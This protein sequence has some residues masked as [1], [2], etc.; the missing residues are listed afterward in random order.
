MNVWRSS[1]Q[2]IEINPTNQEAVTVHVVAFDAGVLKVE[3]PALMNAVGKGNTPGNQTFAVMNTGAASLAYTVTITGAWL[4]CSS[5]SGSVEPN[6]TNTLTLCYVGTESWPAGPDS[7]TMVKIISV[8]GTGATGTVAVTLRVLSLGTFNIIPYADN[9]EAYAAQM[10]LVGGVSGWYGS[11]SSVLVQDVVVK[12]GGTKAAMLPIDVTL[13]NRFVAGTP[14]NVR[15]AMDFRPVRYDFAETN[16]P[17]VDTNTVAMFYV[18]TNGHFVVCNGLGTTSTWCMVSNAFGTTKEFVVTNDTW[19]SIVI[20]LD[21]RHRNW[22]LKANNVLI[23][24]RIGFVTQ[25][26]NGFSGFSLYNSDSFTSYL[27]NVSVNWWDRFKVN[28]VLEHLIRS[29]NGVIPDSIDGAK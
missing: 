7:N 17:A 22:K 2:N 27:D 29:V 8:N 6:G 4:S 13:S 9:F 12:A 19:T 26:T 15:I 28:G 5:L 16:F 21:Y 1:Y 14:L 20:Y 23:T 11:A 24:N 3:P 18:D 25:Q 10:A